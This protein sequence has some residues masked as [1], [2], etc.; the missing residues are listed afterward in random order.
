MLYCF[1]LPSENVFCEKD[2]WIVLFYSGQLFMVYVRIYTHLYLTPC[3]VTLLYTLH[4]FLLTF[5]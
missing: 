5:V 4:R 1:Y 2:E 3:T